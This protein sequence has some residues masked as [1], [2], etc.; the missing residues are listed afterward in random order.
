MELKPLLPK[1][2]QG[3]G[4]SD[5]DRTRERREVDRATRSGA[6]SVV[7]RGPRNVGEHASARAVQGR[8]ARLRES[9]IRENTRNTGPDAP[10]PATA[11]N[12]THR[13][14]G[15]DSVGP[16]ARTGPRARA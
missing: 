15:E 6:K 10:K 3:R 1:A 11:R 2:V 12:M 5:I 13:P 8:G 9:P 16:L 4:R 7:P 14:R